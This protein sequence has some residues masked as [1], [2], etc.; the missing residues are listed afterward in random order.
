MVAVF[1]VGSNSLILLVTDG[2]SD[3]HDEVRI[4]RLGEGLDFAGKLTAEAI[5]RCMNAVD[6]FLPLT[7]GAKILAVG[8][9]ALREATNSDQLLAEFAKRGIDLRV[10]SEDE[11]AGLSYASVATDPA[12]GP[13]ATILDLGGRSMELAD[14]ERRISLPI[15]ASSVTERH[16]T[17]DPPAPSELLQACA[18][19]DSRL[20]PL[21][22]FQPVTRLVLIGGT[23]TTLM[24]IRLGAFDI[25]RIHGASITLEEVSEALTTLAS[26]TADQ[27]LSLPGLDPGRVRAILGGALI[28]ERAMVKL[29]VETAQVS[30]KGLRHAIARERGR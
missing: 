18:E 16:L 13:Q 10:L 23:A 1:D 7:T 9:A 17:S 21:A 22:Q 26:M 29:G 28:L 2:Q 8:T 6:E 19:I 25:E 30:V 27:R 20:E 14:H 3:L 12:F 24:A 5:Q 4:T 11:E 15:G